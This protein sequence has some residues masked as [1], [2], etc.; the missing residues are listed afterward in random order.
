MTNKAHEAAK[1]LH[2]QLVG[3]LRQ[4][5]ACEGWSTKVNYRPGHLADFICDKAKQLYD[6]YMRRSGISG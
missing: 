4:C 5:D 3:H 2:R 1:S 6:I